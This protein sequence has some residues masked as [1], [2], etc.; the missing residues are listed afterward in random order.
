MSHTYA[1]LQISKAAFDEIRGKL[2]EAGYE[3]AFD[4]AAEGGP[5]VDMHGVAVQA[6]PKTP[7]SDPLTKQGWGF[8][9]Q[10]RRAHWFSAGRSL[11]GK[12]GYLGDLTKSQGVSEKPGPDDCTECHRRL[13]RN[14]SGARR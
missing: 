7:E 11:C 3:H 14:Q 9:T 5:V 1:V 2:K 4:D 12:W 10:S 6:V 8:P 13:L